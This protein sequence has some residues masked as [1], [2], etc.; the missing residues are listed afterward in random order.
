MLKIKL[1]LF[2]IVFTSCNAAL[3]Q[4][5]L[6]YSKIDSIVAS[7]NQSKK[8]INV[9][10]TGRI[11][12]GEIKGRYRDSYTI[13]T[14]TNEL[15]AFAASITLTKTHNSTVTVYYFYK[16]R[17]IKVELFDIRQDYKRYN[18]TY[19]YYIDEPE[20]KADVYQSKE[21]KKLKYLRLSAQ[22]LENFR[23]G[24]MRR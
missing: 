24:K 22:H 8:L 3:C 6:T 2:F 4:N 18:S 17:L 23:N 9:L 13:D 11:E 10:D 20:G 7:I 21:L 19:L 1:V 14:A 12:Q 16:S 15:R 5:N